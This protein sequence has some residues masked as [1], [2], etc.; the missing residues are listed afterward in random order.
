[1][2]NDDF[3]VS[4]NEQ[5]EE[6]NTEEDIRRKL[7]KERDLFVE[8]LKGSK[9]CILVAGPTGVGKSTLI[10]TVMNRDIAKVGSGKP[11]T[12]IC[13]CYENEFVRFYDSKG[14]ESNDNAA[15]LFKEDVISLIEECEKKSTADEK[16]SVDV[17]WYSISAG[18]GRMTEFDASLIRT[19]CQSTHNKPLAIVFTKQD[20]ATEEAAASMVKAARQF[21]PQESFPH[22]RIFET[23]DPKQVSAEEAQELKSAIK[24]NQDELF[25]WTRDSLDDAYRQS[26]VL[27][28]MRDLDKKEE[29]CETYIKAATASAVAVVA[30]P[31]PFSDAPLLVGVQ[32]TLMAK[33]MTTYGLN[34]STDGLI[35]SVSTLVTS[36]LGR[37]VAGNLI[38][39][40]PGLGTA[41]G[42][43]I[44]AGVASAITY[45]FGKAT[46]VCCRK[47]VESGFTGDGKGNKAKEIFESELFKLAMQYLK[48]KL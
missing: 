2:A 44:N 30:T 12:Q 19:I 7:N 14:Y 47:V 29:A 21:F 34:L 41:G 32:L 11:V 3:H 39:L 17:V 33:I 5:Y 45:A 15:E 10:N 46:V 20:H 6:Y 26:F 13:D 4:D 35:G 25:R 8:S 16:T 27:A 28:G 23:F 9:P 31:I 1:M 22:I 43:I 24:D 37:T 48:E 38:K 18:S 42:A 40:I 36:V